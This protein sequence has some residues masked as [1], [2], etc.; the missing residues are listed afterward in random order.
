[1]GRTGRK[2]WFLKEWRKRR[3]YSQERL[4]EMIDT[5]K[6]YISELESGKRRYNQELIERLADALSCSPADLLA[7][8]PEIALWSI[9]TTL[10]DKQRR[11]LAAIA[12][13]IKETGE[14]D[15]DG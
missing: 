4:A 7:I 1:M 3:G 11:Q 14:N 10:S 12:E 9:L 15:A 13:A 6:S 8:D 2:Q 5:S